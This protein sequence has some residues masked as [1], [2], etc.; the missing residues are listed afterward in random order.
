[1]PTDET[2]DD[3]LAAIAGLR[4]TRARAALH[5]LVLQV[6]T[7]VGPMMTSTLAALALRFQGLAAR[8]RARGELVARSTQGKERLSLFVRRVAAF[9]SVLWS[10]CAER[11]PQLPQLVRKVRRVRRRRTTTAPPPARTRLRSHGEPRPEPKRRNHR[12][13]FAAAALAATSLALLAY[14][15]FPDDGTE[16]VLPSALSRLKVAADPKPTEQA[17]ATTPAS[18]MPVALAA[19]GAPV[20]SVMAAPAMPM[21]APQVGTPYAAGPIPPP[22]FPTVQPATGTTPPPPV[23]TEHR[24]FSSGEVENGR[25][26]TLRMSLPVERIA[27]ERLEDGFQVTIPGALSLDPAGPIASA[28]PAVSRAM[29]IN[30]GDHSVL[31][32]RFA[33]GQRP[34]YRVEPAGRAIT[35]TIARSG[36]GA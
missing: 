21:A 5:A 35:I 24:S 25:T 22:T 36:A 11:L 23:V 33:D 28:H 13:L 4:A 17:V 16:A 1:M 20:G 7:R 12:R 27:G 19:G 26:F 34:S 2:S 9:A 8:L 15:L 30:R 3:E 10:R 14:A 6:R 29:I 32:I 18:V 31:T